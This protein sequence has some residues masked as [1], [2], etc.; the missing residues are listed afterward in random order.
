MKSKVISFRVNEDVFNVI[1]S[2]CER[3]GVSKNKL[4]SDIISSNLNMQI[5]SGNLTDLDKLLVKLKS[6]V[7]HQYDA[8]NDTH[9]PCLINGTQEDGEYEGKSQILVGDDTI[10]RENNGKF[11]IFD[12]HNQNDEPVWINEKEVLDFYEGQNLAYEFPMWEQ[13]SYQFIRGFVDVAETLLSSLK[14]KL[15]TNKK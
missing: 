3:D 8:Y 9:T 11:Y 1:E 2:I 14:E 13:N 10:I 4:L 12:L 7:M 5:N 6:I 15:E